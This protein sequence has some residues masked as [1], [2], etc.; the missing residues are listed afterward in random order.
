MARA[1]GRKKTTPAR[2][3]SPARARDRNQ[4]G[5]WDRLDGR[6]R[7]IACLVALLA[8][9]FGFFA[10]AVFSGRAL[11]G[12]DTV[13]WRAMAEYMLAYEE[14]TGRQALWA[15]N[16]F[17]GMPGYM[18][19]YAEKIPQLDD[20]PALLRKAIWPVSH[21]IVLLVGTWLLAFFLTK[22]RLAALLA[23]V[24]YGLAT[25]MTFILIAGHNS[26]FITLC[27]APWLVLAFAWALRR[28]GLLAALL[29][30]MALGVNLRGG[31]VQITYYVAF[32]LGVWWVVEGAHAVLRKDWKPFAMATAWLALGGALGV[33]LVAQPYLLHFEYKA[34]TIRGAVGGALSGLDWDYAMGWSQGVGELVTLLA[35]DAY[36]GA[37]PTYWGPKPFTAG[38]HYIGPIVLL[39]AAFA[40]R[41][42]RNR[43][44]LALAITTLLSMLFS[45]GSNFP[46]LNRFMYEHFPMFNA[47]RV[48]E[49]W[50]AITAF[51]LALL[52]A[53]GL[54]G[55]G[56]DAGRGVGPGGDPAAWRALR[57]IFGAVAGVLLLLALA[58][59]ALYDF[60]AP[61]EE[62]R[63]TQSLLAQQP[64]ISPNDPRVAPLVRNYL[65]EQHA[66]REDTFRSEMQR[67]LFFLL[68]AGGVILLFRLGKAPRWAL[69]AALALLATVDLWGVGRRYFNE[70][71]LVRASEV[72]DQI[73]TYDV[74]R[75]ILERQAAAGGPGRFRVLSLESGSPFQHA[76]PSYH[77]E[78]VGGYHGAKLRLAQDYI[79]ALYAEPGTRL[80]NANALDLLGVRYVISP[81]PLPGLTVAYRGEQ[82]GL[83][84][85]ENADVPPRAWL[86]GETEMARDA[87]SAFARLRDPAFDARQT[88]LLYEPLPLDPVPIDSAS[89]ARVEM[90]SWS[91]H[92]IALRVETDAPRLL[93][94]SEVFYPAGWEATVD[95]EAVPIVQVDHMLRGVPVPAGAREVVFRFDPPRHRIGVA[96]GAGSTALV[97]GGALFLLA[98]GWRRRRRQVR[99]SAPGA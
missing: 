19:A 82:T 73:A 66:L 48:P 6:T 75:Y 20:I 54:R 65:A 81:A 84:V 58:P 70:D 76:R 95:G 23:A 61:G 50:L 43:G 94:L 17:G 96:V 38:P 31:H 72:A 46:L 40:L 99:S 28:P 68:L 3:S 7:H 1:R 18:I 39:L 27:F 13:R 4:A 35:A 34:Y 74:D 69:A 90:A 67:S 5:L 78:S 21:F 25:Y 47:F 62:A 91:L 80:P 83:L 97:Y 55:L 33:L 12:D 79:D 57:W 37:S 42:W 24:A 88:A 8:V 22:D 16:A 49:S 32:F 15:P 29:F 98:M 63:L 9:A 86:V 53:F 56:K 64:D 51:A 14:E 77:Y 10:P 2:G 30:A 71:D 26:R 52:A 45:L 36:G 44:V 85:L 87:P 89:V 59:G 92:E 93:V 60:E 11:I 41:Q